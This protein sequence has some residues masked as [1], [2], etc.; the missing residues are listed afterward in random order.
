M[1]MF[2]L[3]FLYILSIFIEVNNFVFFNVVNQPFSNYQFFKLSESY[4]KH[5]RVFMFINLPML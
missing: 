3:Y 2:L 5:L 4:F 1:V